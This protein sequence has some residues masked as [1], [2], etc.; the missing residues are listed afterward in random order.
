MIKESGKR[1]IIINSTKYCGGSKKWQI[2]LQKLLRIFD[3]VKIIGYD[4][5][6][7]NDERFVEFI[8]YQQRYC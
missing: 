2:Y 4:Q 3:K 7:F 6:T 8:A 5:E 1:G